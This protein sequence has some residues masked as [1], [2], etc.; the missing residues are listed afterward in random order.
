[1]HGGGFTSLSAHS[2]LMIAAPMAQRSG[3]R[4][5]SVD[6]GLAPGQKWRA[7][8]DH[9]GA[10]RDLPAQHGAP[11]PALRAGRVDA[12]LDL[13]E[14]MIHVFQPMAP[15]AP[16]SQAAFQHCVAFWDEHLKRR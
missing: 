11:L 16:E 4:T 13:Y 7:T 12:T 2:T 1:M 15:A 10:A 3:L 9:V 8:L 5:I 14:G 6:Y